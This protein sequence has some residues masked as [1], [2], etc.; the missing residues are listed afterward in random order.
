M[1]MEM[2]Q[3]AQSA[4]F[5]RISE[6]N[7]EVFFVGGCVRDYFLQKKSKD[8]DIVVCHMPLDML[9]NEL[10]DFGTIA[11]G[12]DGKVGKSFGVIKYKDKTGFELDIALPRIDRP[13]TQA[14]RLEF[15]KLTGD[16]PT[17]HQAITADSDP[18]LPI[19]EDL[20]RRDFT[21][22][23]IALDMKFRII[24]PYF[25]LK[26]LYQKVMR[27]VDPQAFADDPLRIARLIQFASRFGFTISDETYDLILLHK[28]KLHHISPERKLMELQKIVD[29]N[30]SS[31]VFEE[32]IKQTDLIGPWFGAPRGQFKKFIETIPLKRMS[33]LLHMVSQRWMLSK[34]EVVQHFVKHLKIDT[35][36]QNELR[37]FSYIDSCKWDGEVEERER[38]FQMLQFAK[39][40]SILDSELFEGMGS[41]KDFKSGKFPTHMHQLKIKGTD[42]EEMG[43]FGKEIGVIQKVILSEIFSGKL[44]NNGWKIA[45]FVDKYKKETA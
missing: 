39:D 11:E 21:I 35:P 22:N 19:E 18:Y 43:Y 45:L 34:D 15:Y 38:V 6:L 16:M 13:M 40:D 25:G 7:C 23:A 30:V 2:K 20:K 17:E 28:E 10:R 27:C 31:K 4:L 29:A 9:I 36:T 3:I 41:V 42:L 14:E 1:E 44:E 24:D 32:L 33:E 12:K 26:D 8:I 37:A 5:K